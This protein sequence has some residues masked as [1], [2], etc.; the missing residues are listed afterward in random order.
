MIRYS[1]EKKYTTLVLVVIILV[2]GYVSY[3]G[4]SIDLFPDLDLPILFV[5]AQ[6]AG[7]TPEAMELKITRPL[8]RVLSTSEGLKEMQSTSTDGVS[9]LL[10]T[11]EQGHN[12]D[13]ASIDVSGKI[14]LLGDLWKSGTRPMVLRLNPSMLPV[15]I[16]AVHAENMTPEELTR[17]YEEQLQTKLEGTD[18]V[19]RVQA[20]GLFKTEVQV[21]LSEE[22][23][24]QKNNE[25]LNK[26]QRS[27]DEQEQ[28]IQEAKQ[29]IQE[30]KDRLSNV[31]IPAPSVSI[32][33]NLL[34]ASLSLSGELAEISIRKASSQVYLTSLEQV[35]LLLTTPTE[36]LSETQALILETLSEFPFSLTEENLEEAKSW[37]QEQIQSTQNEIAVLEAEETSL[38]ERLEQATQSIS[39]MAAAQGQ[40]LAQAGNMLLQAQAAGSELTKMEVLLESQNMLLESKKEEALASANLSKLLNMDT[41]TKF[42]MAE[43]IS[44]PIGYIEDKDVPTPLTLQNP[45]SQEELED[46]LLV[47]TGEDALGKIYL[48]DVAKIEKVDNSKDYYAKV[49]GK[50]A[51]LINIQKQSLANTSKVSSNLHATIDEL[52]DLYPGLKI[53]PLMDQGQYIQWVIKA[54]LQNILL[55]GVFAMLILYLFLRDL[56]F[57]LLIALSIPISIVATLVLM[58]FS[59]MTLNLVSMAGLALGVGMMVDNSI[60]VIE[61]IHR[62]SRQGMGL[63]ESSLE[64]AKEM[65]PAITA[66]TM[67]TAF[68]FLPILF[69]QGVARELFTDMALTIAYALLASLV[70]ALS[71]IPTASS[72]QA[73]RKQYVQREFEF[74]RK[75]LLWSLRHPFVVLGISL[76][77]LLG[78]FGILY[79][80]GSIFIPA[81]DTPQI[82]MTI[83]PGDPSQTK[84]E[85][86][87]YTDEVLK[88][89]EDVKDLS[90][91]GAMDSK[92]MT[93]NQN[94]MSVHLLREEG[95]KRSSLA[96]EKEIHEKLQGLPLDIRIQSQSMSMDSLGGGGLSLRLLS[97]NLEEAQEY[98]EKLL[99]EIKDIPG[100]LEARL[101]EE[102]AQRQFHLVLDREKAMENQLTPA[103]VFHQLER[104]L[105]LPKGLLTLEEGLSLKVI[106]ENHHS[107]TRRELMNVE[108]KNSKGELV[109]LS[110]IA[111]LHGGTTQPSIGRINQKRYIEMK[112]VIAPE[113]NIELVSDEIDK[114]IK[115][116][117][118]PSGL[119][120][121]YAGEREQLT[122]TMKDL[123]T[124]LLL[125]FIIIYGIMIIQFQSLLSPFIVMFTIPLAFT[126]GALAL[127]LFGKPLSVIALLGFLVLS[128]VVVNN[129]I[130]FVDTAIRG[131]GSIEEVLLRTGFMRTRPILMTALTTILGLVPLALSVGLG[132]EALQPMGLV[133]IGGLLYATLMTLY[134][135]PV[136][137]KL[138]H[139]RKYKVETQQEQ[140]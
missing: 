111:K 106:Q 134:V 130:V 121:V 21:I 46:L 68:V 109:K 140:A 77:L 17:F 102:E 67:T 131:E 85:L 53:S 126:G 113:S 28:E 74:Y 108:I 127:L 89:L 34:D 23:I 15:M 86:Y 13:S 40:M 110:S 31:S 91:I 61:N 119:E 104:R 26:I 92:S 2:L 33:D 82:E 20:T 125:A 94:A 59:N 57:T 129:G 58:Y 43:N 137:Y 5:V 72:I 41:L 93:G 81:M 1:I 122:S 69:T 139:G 60:V 14:D 135:I 51:L 42:L 16:S 124:M 136:L 6:E 39:N 49:N 38:Q 70:V 64:G 90:L 56:R 103:E 47:D 10:L 87:S 11:F 50:N 52:E 8:E 80:K 75:S 114:K 76:L 63:R 78:S 48:K 118:P 98:G 96:I 84:E 3:T 62:L 97:N 138:F 4:L 7:Q 73:P 100:L 95:S 25:L 128:G 123:T 83:R 101:G 22:K 45:L 116:M 120:V 79:T 27:L 18:G 88:R 117:P 54:I 12:M 44:L 115:E 37:T 133:L 32:P 29:K 30:G 107:L 36:D 105:S 9:T 65:A 35:L 71:L 99:E 24:Q 132:S 112:G 66:S 19:A 55:G